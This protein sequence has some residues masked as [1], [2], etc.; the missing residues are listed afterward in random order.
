MNRYLIMAT[1]IVSGLLLLNINLPRAT[2]S[3][4]APVAQAQA[5]QTVL[6]SIHYLP[7]ILP[8]IIDNHDVIGL[9]KSQVDRLLAWRAANRQDI[10]ATINEII[11]RRANLKRVALSPSVSDAEVAARQTE[12]FELQRKVLDYKLSC[13][14]L[15]FDMFNEENWEGLMFVLAEQGV[16]I[17]VPA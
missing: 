5:P 4:P 15:V 17:D 2:P 9:T 6:E 13:R 16:V 10:L 12:I 11:A 7:V 14:T 1:A 3:S 8:L